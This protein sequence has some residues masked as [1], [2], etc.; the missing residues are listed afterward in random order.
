LVTQQRWA[1]AVNQYT[2]AI[3]LDPKKTY[4]SNRAV[5]F[6]ALGEFEKAEADCKIILTKDTKHIKAY[7]QRTVARM[8]LKKWREA[9]SDILEVIKF[10]PDHQKARQMLEEIKKEVAKLPKQSR[11]DVLNF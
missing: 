1:E 6:N 7:F 11:E 9:Q 10:Q 2:R 4:F 8:A 3:S 5:S